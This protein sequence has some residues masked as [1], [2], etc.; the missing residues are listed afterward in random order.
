M[1]DFLSWTIETIRADKTM[2][3]DK[4]RNDW[5][6]LCAS[7]VSALLNGHTA[8]VMTDF[9]R[10]WFLRYAVSK[11]NHP[12]QNRPYLPFV[13]FKSMFPS[14]EH[15]RT[16]EDLEFTKDMLDL[17]FPNGYFFWYIGKSEDRRS[18]LAKSK[19]DSFMWAMDEE[20]QNG[21]YLSSIDEHLDIKLL[22]LFGLLNKTINAALFNEVNIEL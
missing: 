13:D 6:P 18:K 15:L 14:I 3:L 22:Q 20:I 11:I 8:I 4:R 5:S 17:T 7:A 19:D 9:D 21:F 10:E 1:Q 2:W 16:D 12:S